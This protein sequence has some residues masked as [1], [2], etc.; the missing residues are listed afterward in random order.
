[1]LRWT[2]RQSKG[3]HMP[4]AVTHLLSHDQGQVVHL[5][6]LGVRFMLDGERTGGAFSLVEHPLPPRALGAPLHTHHN[7]D[8][9]SYVLVARQS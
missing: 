9:C 2:Q 1:M 7:E 5:L 8:E 3:F 6:A 4:T